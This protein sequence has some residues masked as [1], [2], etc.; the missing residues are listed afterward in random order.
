MPNKFNNLIIYTLNVKSFYDAN[1]D[2]VGDFKGLLQQL[3][4]LEDLGIN[5]ISLLPFYPSPMKDEGYDVADFCNIHP[6]FGTLEQFEQVVNEC[7]RRGIQIIIELILNHTSD[8]HEWFKRAVLAEPETNARDFYIWSDTP[9]RLADTRVMFK[10]FE[11]SNWAWNPTAKAYYFHRFYSHQPDLNFENSEVQREMFRIADFWLNLGVDGLRLS[12]APFIGKREGTNCENLPEAHAFLKKMRRYVDEKHPGKLLVAES[13]MWPEDAASYFGNGDECHLNFHFPLMPRMFM[14]LQT[15]NTYPIID[16]IE[17]TPTLPE[18]CNWAI[19]LR[20][21]DD[22][23]LEMVSEE[24][25]DYLYKVFAQDHGAKINQGIRRR[26][27]PL[28]GNDR[29]KIELLNFLMFSLPGVPVLYYGDE[30]GMGDNIYLGDRNGIRTPMQWNADRN[31]GFSGANPQKLFLPVIR[32]PQYR[33]ESVN[34]ETQASNPSSLLWWTK[35]LIALRKRL[36]AL[37]AGTLRFIETRN[38]KVLA[39]IREHGNENVLIIANLS[40]FSQYAQLDLSNFAGI[41]PIDIFSQNKFHEI[42]KAPYPFTIGA[43]GYHWFAIETATDEAPELDAN[44]EE[45]AFVLQLD[46]DWEDFLDGFSTKNRFEKGILEKYLRTCRWF[47]GKSRSV[48][49]INI[50]Q[51]PVVAFGEEQQVYFLF[52]TVNYTDGLPE[53]YFLPLSFVSDRDTIK[54]Y[55]EKYPKSVLCEVAFRDERGILI[56]AIYSE[57]FRNQI[58]RNLRAGQKIGNLQFQAGKVLL[59]YDFVEEE[60]S[61]ELLKAEQSNTSVIYNNQFFFKIY[62]K[63]DEDINPDLELVRFLSESTDFANSPQYAGGIEFQTDETSSDNT[64]LRQ[65]VLGMMQ[66]KIPNQGEAWTSTLDALGRFYEKVL[67]K[68][69]KQSPPALVYAEK[70]YFENLPL[71]VQKLIGADLHVQMVKLAQRTAEMHLALS[72]DRIDEA[73]KPEPFTQHYQRSLYSQ[74][75]KLVKEKMDALERLY[76]TLPASIQPEVLELLGYREAMMQCFSEIFTVP[77]KAEKIRIHGDYHLGQVLFDGKDF[78]IIDYEGEPASPISERRLKKTPFKDVAG[79]LRSLHY[80]AYGQ[81]LLNPYYRP[82]DF[83]ILEQWAEQWYYYAGNVFLTTYLDT[84]EGAT[85]IPAEREHRDLIL[86]TYTLEKAIYEIGYEI[87]SRPDWLRIPLRGA[88]NIMRDYVK[89]NKG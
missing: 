73:F 27:A 2:G 44:G 59:D 30:I 8:Q 62:R 65:T 33:Y 60:L 46:G 24:E 3:D 43:Y 57:E 71:A 56:D 67:I 9:D 51:H 64:V 85:F 82:E 26:L 77:I 11:Q 84:A 52:V 16:I 88:L 54:Y 80:A 10:D 89:G 78:Y 66:N 21:H 70:M 34:V 38:P 14:A 63:L 47:G 32:D 61:S 18:G 13:N 15:E 25:R 42:D 75:R 6:D 55:T 50:T 86:R 48:L 49:S 12:S 76:P 87:N 4:Y 31:A 23:T 53:T 37:S 79:M 22:L 72:S 81:L 35:N 58:F 1:A 19:F 28:L 41:I 45:E 68:S 40:K 39:F 74:H 36:P 83:A 17:Q 29:R 7:H 5:A 69:G 20:N